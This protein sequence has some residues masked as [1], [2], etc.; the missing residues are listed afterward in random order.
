MKRW[1]LALAL[2]IAACSAADDG[3]AV[4]PD[5]VRAVVLPYMAIVPFH[6]AA[7]EGYFAQ[8]NLD[9]EFVHLGR[10]QE[11]MAALATGEV[12]VASGFLTINELGLAAGGADI[13]MVAS[14]A[15]LPAG[16][17][18]HAAIVLRRELWEDGVLEDPERIRKLRFELNP[19]L[20]LGYWVDLLLARY[21][22]SLDD[23][24]LVDLP[25]PAAVAAMANGSI[26]VTADSDP[27]ITRHTQSGAAVVW[28]SIG[29]LAP[30]YVMSVVMYG[31]SLINDRR[32][33]GERFAVAMLQALRRYAE[34]KT[35]RNIELVERATGIERSELEAACWPTVP[36]DGRVDPAAFRDYQ[37]WAVA[38]GQ[39][40]RVVDD[41]ELFDLSFM[42]H[43]NAALER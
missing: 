26:D 2:L 34:G 8:Q 41:A 9:V 1:S 14:L 29:D 28:A 25:S 4:A 19:L 35:A 18:G 15:S 20:P 31:P 23:V 39:L 6:I 32:E 27:W 17:C 13:R 21:G 11:I 7:E 12:D 22:L 3:A 5:R 37:E 36:T 30:D 16:D 10:N 40:E 42:E 43:A 33:V 24:E 38:R